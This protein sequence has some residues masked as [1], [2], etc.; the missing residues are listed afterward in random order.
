MSVSAINVEKSASSSTLSLGAADV[1]ADADEL[2]HLGRLADDRAGD[3]REHSH[4]LEV[5]AQRG[6]LGL[7]RL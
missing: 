3:R 5:H 6:D 7:C 2:A 4:V 1:G